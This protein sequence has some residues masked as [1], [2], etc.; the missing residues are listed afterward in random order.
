M[1][2]SDIA[3][4]RLEIPA[5]PKTNERGPGRIV[6][7]T[8]GAIVRYRDGRTVGPIG[9]ELL[10][11]ALARGARIIREEPVQIVYG[12]GI[13]DQW[14]QADA[15]L[16]GREMEVGRICEEQNQLTTNAINSK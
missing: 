13:A 15:E 10:R 3:I 9:G 7:G 1:R 8:G 2:E 5:T 14:K 11:L 4:V 12:P 6:P 16:A